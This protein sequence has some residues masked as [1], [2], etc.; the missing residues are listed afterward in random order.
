MIQIKNVSKIYKTKYNEVHALKDINLSFG[1]CG[2]VFILGKSGC[3]KSTLLNILGGLDSVTSG[4]VLVDNKE[5]SKLKQSELDYFRNYNVGF[6]FQGYNLVDEYNVYENIEL[7]LDLQG[8]PNVKEKISTALGKVDLE[9]YEKRKIK[10]LSG[11]QQQRVAIARALVK[12]STYI[13]AD[14]PTGNLDSATSEDIFTLL[15]QL[16]KEKLIIVVSHDRENAEQYGDR[17]IEMKDYVVLEDRALTSRIHGD[18]SF[19]PL[20]D[21]ENTLKIGT[22]RNKTSVKQIFKFASRNMWHR[23]IRLSASILLC[24]VSLTA[25]ILSIAT[26]DQYNVGLAFSH[27]Y[28]DLNIPAYIENIETY[29][30]DSISYNCKKLTNEAVNVIKKDFVGYYLPIYSVA[31]KNSLPPTNITTIDETA[32]KNFGMQVQAKT[33]ILAIICHKR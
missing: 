20:N 14:E 9:G 26:A 8:E 16:S 15:K 27:A 11:G 13:L 29:Q 7:A 18:S 31:S 30:N 33:A 25:L 32:F 17:I 4:E 12:N 10:E 3:G 1:E 2:L 23:W 22:K 19:M 5:I 24:I 28:K 6:I 21:T